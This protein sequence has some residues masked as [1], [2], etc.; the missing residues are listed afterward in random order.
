MHMKPS[1]RRLPN[2][3]PEADDEDPFADIEEDEDEL[4]ENETVLDNYYIISRFLCLCV[5]VCGCV[6]VCVCVC[7]MEERC[8]WGGT[9]LVMRNL[10]TY[11]TLYCACE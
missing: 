6:S 2:F 4:E 7:V 9:G 1:P 10:H 3:C 8:L 11:Y 5:C